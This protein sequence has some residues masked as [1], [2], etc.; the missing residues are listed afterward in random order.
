M[1]QRMEQGGAMLSGRVLRTQNSFFYVQT[2][3]GV[4]DCKLRGRFKKKELICPGDRVEIQLLSDGTGVIE[5][6]LERQNLL[7]RP[8][9]ANV[10]QVVL[11]FAAAQPDIH[12]LLLNR[13]LVLAES[14]AIPHILICVNKIDLLPMEDGRTVLSDYESIGYPVLR[15]SAE[16][17][18]GMDDM[19]RIL[20]GRTTV[21][22]GPSGV[23]KSSLLNRLDPSFDLEV[24]RV[25]EKIKRG[26]HT[27]RLARLFPCEGG[28]IVDT[29]G[30]SSIEMTDIEASE[31]V[32]FFP[33][34]ASHLGGCRFTPCTHSH[35]PQ[36]SIKEAVEAGKIFRERY[37]AYLNL[38]NEIETRKKEYP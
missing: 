19:R 33:E 31:L 20:A 10:D 11:T 35:E 14:S 18:W 32:H 26:R 13:F 4:I 27:T 8:A 38:L 5:G 3:Q 16:K 36:C 22:S 9:V 37:E 7:K 15:V 24:G 6:L 23:G 34:F 29:P 1:M 12:P 28:Y 17:G 30:F 21:F 25:S 2:G